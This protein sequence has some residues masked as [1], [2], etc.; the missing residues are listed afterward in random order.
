MSNTKVEAPNGALISPSIS[1]PK[2]TTSRN[3]TKPPKKNTES[4]LIAKHPP[5][6]QKIVARLHQKGDF[7]IFVK[8]QA[9]PVAVIAR[10][11]KM[12]TFLNQHSCK[13][14]FVSLKGLGR[15]IDTTFMIGCRLQQAGYRVT[16]TTATEKVVDE[17]YGVKEQDKNSPDQTG[18]QEEQAAHEKT[19]TISAD[20]KEIYHKIRYVSSVTV[21]VHIKKP[22]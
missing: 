9:K 15:A 20:Q 12:V 8:P 14:T 16:F 22:S 5:V 4:L 3:S 10:V 19:Q 6:A 2:S 18:D 11:T 17:M 7:T 1:E 21:K 13:R